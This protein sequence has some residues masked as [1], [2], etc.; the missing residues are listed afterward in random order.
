MFIK[1]QEVATINII[2]RIPA[3]ARYSIHTLMLHYPTSWLSE[4]VIHFHLLPTFQ[5]P[6]NREQKGSAPSLEAQT[7]QG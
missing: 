4:Y 3:F 7:S 2:N 1:I 5:H 6:G